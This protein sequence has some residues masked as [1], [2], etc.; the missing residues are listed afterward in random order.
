MSSRSVQRIEKIWTTVK[1]LNIKYGFLG[2]DNKVYPFD[3]YKEEAFDVKMDK[4]YKLQTPS[5]LLKSKC[6]VCYDTVELL[7]SYFETMK[8]PHETIYLEKWSDHPEESHTFLVSKVDGRIFYPEWSFVKIRGLH[9]E[10]KDVKS[11]VYHVLN[12]MR[13][14][15]YNKEQH[16]FAYTYKAPRAGSN[17][18]QFMEHC[19]RSNCILHIENGKEE[20]FKG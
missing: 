9:T 19:E 16:I 1:S 13:K 7:R 20:F 4:L 6:G 14:T 11:V 12:N 8:I 3:Q 17:I 18:K 2:K 15:F 10:F 5:E